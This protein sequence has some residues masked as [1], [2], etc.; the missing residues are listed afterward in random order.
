MIAV[1]AIRERGVASSVDFANGS[2]RRLDDT[3]LSRV[4]TV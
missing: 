2:V 3:R 4:P 1:L